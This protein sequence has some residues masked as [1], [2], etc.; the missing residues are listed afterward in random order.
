M[1]RIVISVKMTL[2][3]SPRTSDSRQLS[4]IGAGQTRENISQKERPTWKE[5]HM[6][7]GAG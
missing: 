3:N 2:I 6:F 1:M 4:W 7:G 5:R